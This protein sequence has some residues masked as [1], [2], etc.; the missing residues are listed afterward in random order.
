MERIIYDTYE[1]GEKR[2]WNM[3]SSDEFN[4]KVLAV[5]NMYRWLYDQGILKKTSFFWKDYSDMTY[6]ALDAKNLIPFRDQMACSGVENAQLAVHHIFDE[7]YTP[8]LYSGCIELGWTMQ[9]YRDNNGCVSR[10]W[11]CG[12]VRGL[13]TGAA[14]KVAKVCEKQ[15]PKKA[16]LKAASFYEWEPSNLPSRKSLDVLLQKAASLTK[17]PE[18]KAKN[19]SHER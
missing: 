11:E 9:T 3:G 4:K 17:K 8:C 1:K 13:G 19:D 7:D 18:N 14:Q 12:M 15:G 2:T 16:L 6:F 5:N 10:S